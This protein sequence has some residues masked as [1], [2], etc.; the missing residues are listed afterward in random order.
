MQAGAEPLIALK[1][2]S[3]IL[4]SILLIFN[5][6]SEGKNCMLK[7]LGNTACRQGTIQNSGTNTFKNLKTVL[8]TYSKW[9][10]TE[11]TR[12]EKILLCKSEETVFYLWHK[13]Y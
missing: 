4:K 3:K 6:K 2:I 8:G 7:A 10:F 5:F 13:W 1:V 12:H 11:V 9:R